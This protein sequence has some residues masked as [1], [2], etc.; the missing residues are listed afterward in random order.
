MNQKSI[1]HIALYS[2][3][4]VG[5]LVVGVLARQ[6]VL[7]KGVDDFSSN[8]AFFATVIV[9]M[10]I[11]ASL[12]T[13]FN[14]FLLPR[15]EAF[16][17]RFSAFQTMENHNDTVSEPEALTIEDSNQ[18]IP[19]IIDPAPAAEETI[20]EPSE[21]EVMRT[22]AIAENN[23]VIQTKLE[24]VLNYTKQT[25]V[26]YMSEEDLNRLCT[27][28]AEYSSGDT[29]S[30]VKDDSQLKSIDIMHFGW[31]IGKAFGIKRIHT[32]TFI[33]NVFAHTLRDL[34][35]ATIE[36]KMSHTESE[37]K[38]KLNDNIVVTLL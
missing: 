31:N 1:E 15:I 9:L 28:V 7:S 26:A 29:L 17:L 19:N 4:L 12:Q 33:K 8:V 37:C 5:T 24:K 36:R 32:A 14:Q 10:A 27:Y 20:S 13:T 25:M 16:L 23:R 3:V 34:E 30:P 11:Y 35:I 2:L 21:Y 38:I 22:N 6:F 18:A